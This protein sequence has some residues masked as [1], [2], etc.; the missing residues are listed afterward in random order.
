[1]RVYIGPEVRDRFSLCLDPGAHGVL[2]L[3]FVS[4]AFFRSSENVFFLFFFLIRSFLV[5]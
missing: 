1:M 2:L 3:G 4:Q 5:F